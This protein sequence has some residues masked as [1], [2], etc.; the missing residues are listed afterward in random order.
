MLNE[1]DRLSAP[2]QEL[3]M[4]APLLV[5]ILIAG[6]DEQIDKQELKSA[7]HLADSAR[8]KEQV[9]ALFRMAAEDFED[10]FKIILQSLPQEAVERNQVIIEDLRRLNAVFPKINLTFAKEY[11]RCLRFVAKRI[12]EASG[13]VLGINSIGE[14]EAALINLPMIAEPTIK[15]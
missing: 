4:K 10:K 1:L 12:A 13:G 14:E 2:E 8:K 3:M 9:S 11:L 5:C 15:A 6:A 7:M